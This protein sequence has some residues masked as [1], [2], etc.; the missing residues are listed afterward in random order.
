[1]PCQQASNIHPLRALNIHPLLRIDLDFGLSHEA[2]FDLFLEPIGTAFDIDRRGVMQDTVQDGRG[3]HRIAEDLVPLGEAPV[4]SHDQGALLIA[5]GDELEEQ[6]RAVA[7]D[8]D[9]ADLVDDQ[10]LGLAVELQPLFDFVF[11]IGLRQGRDQRH[12]LGEVGPVALGYGLDAERHRQMRFSYPGRAQEDDVF[13]VGDEPA[14]GQVFDP[15]AVDRRLE[16]E[17][18]V[19]QRF[20]ERELGHR[21]ADRDVLLLLGGDFPRQ[22]LVE[23]VGI[24]HVLLGCFFQTGLELVVDPV[25]PQVLQVLL[26]TGEAH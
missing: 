4:R 26:D 19:L 3:D 1:V 6:M 15:L 17:V 12:G 14:S 11:G 25:Q 2:R 16:G 10:E 7:I 23:E 24:G 21:S 20:D 5:A 18:E 13:A 22:Q 8:R 9:V